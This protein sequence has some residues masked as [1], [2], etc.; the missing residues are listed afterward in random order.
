MMTESQDLEATSTYGTDYTS[1]PYLAKK[2]KK[3]LTRV[4]WYQVN[5]LL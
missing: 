1:Y 2:K 4:I 5:M 3:V